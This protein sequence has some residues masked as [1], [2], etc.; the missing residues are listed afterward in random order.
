MYLYLYLYLYYIFTNLYIGIQ[1][2]ICK[3]IYIYNILYIYI[4][5][6]CY[7]SYISMT[8][9]EIANTQKTISELIEVVHTFSSIKDTIAS[10]NNTVMILTNTIEIL[11]NTENSKNIKMTLL[12]NRIIK[13]EQYSKESNIIITDNSGFLETK[14]PRNTFIEFAKNK[15]DTKINYLDIVEIHRLP[16]RNEQQYKTIVKFHFN[17]TK[18]NLLKTQKNSKIQTFT[19]TNI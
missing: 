6:F 2:I 15:L 8:K 1:V 4:Y 17:E 7:N 10:L 3:S 11:D 9:V 16:I 5:L 19:L 13:L 12:E 14:N 18:F